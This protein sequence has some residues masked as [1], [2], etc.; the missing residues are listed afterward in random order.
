MRLDYLFY[1]P[2]YQVKQPHGAGADAGAH[3]RR[4][5]PR[6][7]AGDHPQHSAA[8]RTGAGGSKG[9]S[10]PVRHHPARN[11]CQRADR[12]R[13]GNE[14][15]ISGGLAHWARQLDFSPYRLRVTGTA[16]S[17]KSQLALAEYQATLA[18]R[19][20]ALPLLQSGPWPTISAP[21]VPEGAGSP[22]TPSASSACA[23]PGQ[24]PDFSQPGAFERLV[25][26]AAK[27]PVDDGWRFDTVIVDEGRIFPRPGATS[28]SAMPRRRRACCGSKTRC[29][30]STARSGGVARLVGMHSFANYRCPRPVVRMLQPLL[31]A[32]MPIEA[33]SPLDA[34]DVEILTYRDGRRCCRR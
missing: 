8:R 7:I 6:R 11:R 33:A 13:A 24:A 15:R 21:I 10:L 16:G 23:P 19:A 22:S 14:N 5:S 25:D 20:A 4:Q 1:R 34:G 30:T 18:R 12:P 31:P 29:R 32:D 2:D 26:D 9:A 28:L 17:G 27:L 3:R